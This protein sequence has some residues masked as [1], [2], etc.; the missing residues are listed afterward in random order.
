MCWVIFLPIP[1]TCNF[2]ILTQ[3]EKERE[4]KINGLQVEWSWLQTHLTISDRFAGAKDTTRPTRV[5]CHTRE[6]S[7]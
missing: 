2:Q 4:S 7:C 6:S 3:R 1:S 5:T